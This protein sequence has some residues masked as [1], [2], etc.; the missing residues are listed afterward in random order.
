MNCMP[1]S[2]P[3]NVVRR[4]SLLCSGLGSGSPLRS[5]R[6][7]NYSLGSV[8][9]ALSTKLAILLVFGSRCIRSI[10]GLFVFQRF[11]FDKG[12]RLSSFEGFCSCSASYKVWEGVRGRLLG[13]SWFVQR[14][15]FVCEYILYPKDSEDGGD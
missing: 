9:K 7:G 3:S 4:L 11:W 10:S 6:S 15:E 14:F 8:G 12:S 5:I 13:R 2:S 1:Y